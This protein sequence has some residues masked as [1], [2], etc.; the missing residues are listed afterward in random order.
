MGC[1]SWL[2]AQGSRKSSRQVSGSPTNLFSRMTEPRTVSGN[3]SGPG[4]GSLGP[5][6]RRA[7]FCC[8]PG[9]ERRWILSFSVSLQGR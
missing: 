8:L 2:A 7:S 6:G 1:G 9:C 4:E 3:P 5:C